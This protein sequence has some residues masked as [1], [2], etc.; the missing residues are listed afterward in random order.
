MVSTVFHARY[1]SHPF[2]KSVTL[3]PDVKLYSIVHRVL[4]SLKNLER[5]CSIKQYLKKKQSVPAHSSMMKGS[6]MDTSKMRGIWVSETG[7]VDSYRFCLAETDGTFVS[8]R[9]LGSYAKDGY[10]LAANIV[11]QSY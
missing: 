9:C 11:S 8:D 10:Q 6:C 7:K 2:Y 4:S 3:F 5:D 1:T